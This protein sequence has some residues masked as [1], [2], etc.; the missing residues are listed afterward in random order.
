[1][2]ASPNTYTK[3]ITRANPSLIVILLDGSNSMNESWG[4]G[5]S[6]SEGAS[7]ALNRTLRDIA[8]NA[9]YSAEDGIRDYINLAVYT[10][11]TEPHD[12]QGVDWTLGQTSE[13]SC[14]YMSASEWIPAA[15]RQ[16]KTDIGSL[17]IWI[18]PYAEGW[19]PMCKAFAA[20]A[21][22]VEHHINN[23]PESFPPIVIN[24]TD[25]IPTDHNDDWNQFSRAASAITDQHTEDGNAMLFNIHIDGSGQQNSVLFP[26]DPVTHS[27]YAQHMGEISSVLP[28][29]MVKRANDKLSLDISEAARGYCLNAD[30]QQLSAFLQIGTF[31]PVQS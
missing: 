1:M 23:Y 26:D 16:E 6:L 12:G 2:P 18:E 10:Y 25:G 9:C 17:P 14:S 28:A 31:V 5:G 7:F 27:T 20:A 8:Q 15:L 22:S 29:N 3:K 4:G 19:T 11:G 13:P 30:L 21:R 24:I